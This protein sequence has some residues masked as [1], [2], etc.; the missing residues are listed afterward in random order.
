MQDQ[1]SPGGQPTGVGPRLKTSFA[2]FVVLTALL[3]SLTAMSIDI[4]LPSL[5]QIGAAFSVAHA[6]ETQQILTSYMVGLGIGQLRLGTALRPL[7]AQV[8]ALARAVCLCARIARLSSGVD[9]G[10]HAGCTRGPGFRWR[11]RSRHLGCYRARPVR[12]AADGTR[13]VDRHDGL[14][15]RAD[16]RAIHGPGAGTCRQL[17]L[18][19][20]RPAARRLIGMVWA[21]NR[22]S[23]TAHG[24]A[25]L[26]RSA[27][28][29]D[30]VR[31]CAIA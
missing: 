31:F 30:A 27:S 6:N 10:G 19:L 17:A 23:E 3:I 15:R 5:P 22:L 2:E 4:M 11:C 25:A 12:G 18:E 28:S 8:S 1:Q 16:L 24:P 7:R 21:G 20:L 29:P 9:I 14:H 26:L 13:H